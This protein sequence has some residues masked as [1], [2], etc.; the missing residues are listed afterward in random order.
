MKIIHEKYMTE[1]RFE[2]LEEIKYTLR[3]LRAKKWTQRETANKFF[4]AD[5]QKATAKINYQ[6]LC[7]WNNVHC[8]GGS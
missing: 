2:K 4:K 3:V 1:R 5:W 8:F 6:L 7:Y